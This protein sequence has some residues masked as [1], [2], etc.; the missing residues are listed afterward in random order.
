[1]KHLY[2]NQTK[3]HRDAWNNLINEVNLVSGEGVAVL[4]LKSMAAQLQELREHP[5]RHVKCKTKSAHNTRMYRRLEHY[6][7]IY[8]RK[9]H[10]EI[11][12]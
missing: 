10:E 1:M 2:Q 9:S 3:P 7:D 6:Y 11:T 8:K 4:W 5:P 12:A